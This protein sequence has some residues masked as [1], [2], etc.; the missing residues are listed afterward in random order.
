M[1][2]DEADSPDDSTQD[3]AKRALAVPQIVFCG[4]THEQ[5]TIYFSTDVRRAV[6]YGSKLN[7]YQIYNYPKVFNNGENLNMHGCQPPF[8]EYPLWSGSTFGSQPVAGDKR[9]RELPS[10]ERVI[11]DRCGNLC[12]ITW[13]PFPAPNNAVEDCIYGS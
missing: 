12:A 9:Q 2:R 11:F 4:E 10:G 8:Y 3:I 5:S 6:N 7:R 13:H 1:Q